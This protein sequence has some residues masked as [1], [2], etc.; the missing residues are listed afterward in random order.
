MKKIAV[1]T[2]KAFL[3]ERKRE[4]TYTQ[5]F[6]V[7]DSSFEVVF[8]TSLSIAEKAAFINRVL[9][10][11]FDSTGNFHP[12]YVTP[13]MRATILQMC[14]NVPAMTQKNEAGSEGAS[15]LD[16]DAMD[17]LYMALDLDKL[18]S[19]EYKALAS[20]LFNLCTQAIEWRKSYVLA[21]RGTDASL[22]HLLDTL[23]EKA[24]RV[25]ADDLMQYAGTLS[26]AVKGME[27]GEIAKKLIELKDYR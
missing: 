5:T 13:M 15:M 1:N 26:E 25:D 12:E 4:D 9:S 17:K 22:R 18:D 6:E 21:N 19:C 11:C 27:G 3:K 16:L 10:G 14:T 8:R 7:A 20:E 2:V 24:E 23:A